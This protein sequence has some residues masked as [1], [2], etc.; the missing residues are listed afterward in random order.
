[1]T[2]AQGREITVQKQVNGVVEV[3]F[4][5]V[6]KDARSSPDYQAIGDHFISVIIRGVP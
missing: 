5:E 6:C 4:E 1:M 2:V 3:S